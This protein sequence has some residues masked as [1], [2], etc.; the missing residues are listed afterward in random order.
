MNK[1]SL[2]LIINLYC[3]NTSGQFTSNLSY[4]SSDGDL[5]TPSS[6]LENGQY[7]YLNFF[8][9]TCGICNSVASQ[10]NEA[11]D[12][13]NENTGNL[14][15]LGIE[16][17][18]TSAECEEFRSTHESSFPVIAGS[19]GGSS[20]FNLFNQNGYPG[21]ILIN[22]SGEIVADFNYSLILNL[23]ENLEAY[24][25][26]SI[27]ECSLIDINFINYNTN[28]SNIELE[29]NANSYFLYNYPSFLIINEN[30]D[31][32][33]IEQVNYY[34]LSGVTSHMLEVEYDFFSWTENLELLLYSGFTE[35]IECSFNINFSEIMKVGCTDVN[36]GN[37]SYFAEIDNGS[38]LYEIDY[39]NPVIDLNSGWNIIGFSCINEMDAQIAFMPYEEELIIL[40]NYLG[41]AYLPEFGF[42]GIGALIPGFGYQL[43][44]NNSINN[45]NLCTY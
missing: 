39:L 5:I 27:N 17:F 40:K 8:S 2:L 38:C 30:Y 10:I 19:E 43:K 33:A 31:T 20:I 44:I 22:P 34:G 7:I 13:Y 9:T 12:H 41:L 21:G 3:L 32:L 24:I 16:Y 4:T 42:N 29:I 45:F 36:A 14:Y 37:Y 15:I 1:F 26:P 25:L 11:Y 28:N 18:S 23:H 6:I 35:N